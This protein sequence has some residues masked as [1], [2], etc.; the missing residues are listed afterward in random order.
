[1]S[2]PVTSGHLKHLHLAITTAVVIPIAFMYGFYPNVLFDLRPTTTDEL[3]V[4]KA[5]MGLY[6]AF[7]GFWILGMLLPRFWQPATQSNMLFL[8]GLAA[9]RTLSMCVDGIPS[10]LF[11]L[12]T[13]GEYVLGFYALYQLSRQPI[14]PDEKRH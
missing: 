12:G 9:G 7:G 8:F 10:V 5:I 14:H 3:N 6:I 1:M 13:F 4:Y 2:Q 11:C